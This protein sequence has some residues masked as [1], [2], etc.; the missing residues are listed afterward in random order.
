MSLGQDNLA[1]NETISEWVTSLLLCFLYKIVMLTC[2]VNQKLIPQQHAKA[3][4]RKPVVNTYCNVSIDNKYFTEYI[5]CFLLILDCILQLQPILQFPKHLSTVLIMYS[6]FSIWQI[7]PTTT[8]PVVS[9]G[10]IT[11]DHLTCCSN[12]YFK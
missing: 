1:I 3:M 11:G 5:M 9:F 7:C 10:G 8:N 6:L 2:N 4:S 12:Q